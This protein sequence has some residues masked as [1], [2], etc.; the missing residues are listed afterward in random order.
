MPSNKRGDLFIIMAYQI[1]HNRTH[2][3][4]NTVT[5]QAGN[6]GLVPRSGKGL[7]SSPKHPD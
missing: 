1:V 5:G 3:L 2:I 7:F 6:R 4:V